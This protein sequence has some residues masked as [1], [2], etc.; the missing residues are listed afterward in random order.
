MNM[1]E[2]EYE[3]SGPVA[4]DHWCPRCRLSHLEAGKHYAD[5][6]VAWPEAPHIQ[7]CDRCGH[8]EAVRAMADQPAIGYEDWPLDIEEILRE[9]RVIYHGRRQVADA[10]VE[11]QREEEQDA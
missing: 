10:D 5:S 9:D 7:I 11:R 3:S 1:I 6:R 4:R 2:D 8:R